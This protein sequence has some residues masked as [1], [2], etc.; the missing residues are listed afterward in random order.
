[1]DRGLAVNPLSWD[2]GAWDHPA[3]GSLSGGPPLT[4]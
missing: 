3:S 2:F 4:M 1:M